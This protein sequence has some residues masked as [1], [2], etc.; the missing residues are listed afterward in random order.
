MVRFSCLTAVLL[1]AGCAHAGAGGVAEGSRGGAAAAPA[2]AMSPAT[3]VLLHDVEVTEALLLVAQLEGGPLVVEPRAQPL[4][5]CAR[6]SLMAPPSADPAEIRAL[7]ERAI[8]SVGLQ[9]V[10]GEEGD[11]VRRRRGVRPPSGCESLRRMPRRRPAARQ[12]APDL[13]IEVEEVDEDV[14]EVSGPDVDALFA[15]PGGDGGRNAGAVRAFG[16]VRAVPKIGDDGIAGFKLLR[17]RPGGL[18]DRLGL[19]NGDV[20]VAVNGERLGT[21]E[22]AL[23]ALASLSEREA[24]TLEL[25]RDGERREL[26]YRIRRGESPPADGE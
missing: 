8:R 15:A 12:A 18:A 13:D 7:V 6:I 20:V 1:I 4:A 22:A 23:A 3:G 2:E 17:V 19:C 11:V 26:E 9:I 25:E 24:V 16:G 14:F 5:R 10:R 21:P